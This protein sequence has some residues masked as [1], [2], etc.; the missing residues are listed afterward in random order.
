MEDALLEPYNIFSVALFP[1]QQLQARAL[2][3]LGMSLGAA[4]L[5]SDLMNL[6][7]LSR[8][9]TGPASGWETG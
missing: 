3:C 2:D 8:L 6:S 7:L 4:T 9:I 5:L 1:V